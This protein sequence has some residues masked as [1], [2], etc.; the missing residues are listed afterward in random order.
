VRRRPGETLSPVRVELTR[1]AAVSGEIVDLSGAPVAGTE[2]TVG[3]E[4]PASEPLGTLVADRNGR[5]R[6]SSLAAGMRYYLYTRA[7]GFA[8]ALTIVHAP[9][10][11]PPPPDEFP[12]PSAVAK[13]LRI[14]L[15]TGGSIIGKV[16]D[17]TG[18]PLDD[19]H[20]HLTPTEGT[21][22]WISSWCG[23]DAFR[24]VRSG[25]AGAFEFVHLAANRYRLRATGRGLAPWSREAIVVSGRTARIDLGT[26]TLQ[27][28]GILD[29]QVVDSRGAPVPAASA[30]LSASDG[31]PSF[32]LEDS[33]PSQAVTGP[34][35]KV[36]FADL[37]PGARYDLE[38]HHSEHPETTVKGISIPTA[39][40]LRIE[41]QEGRRL[42]GHV[43]GADGQPIAGASL[44]VVGT[45]HQSFLALL[46]SP[47]SVT[48]AKGEFSLSG[49]APGT[50]QLEAT[51]DGFR[52]S[53]AAALIPDVESAR[54]VEIVL[55][56]AGWLVGS[57]RDT[58]GNPVD[59][60]VAVTPR[61]VPSSP[62][63]GLERSRMG[64]TD[65]S[66]EYRVE[67]LD[68]GTYTVTARPMRRMGSGKPG[69]PIEIRLG[70]NTLDIVVE[71]E[72]GWEVSG[73]VVDS[74]G[75]PVDDVTLQLT[76]A[77]AGTSPVTTSFADGSFV[78]TDVA[79]GIYTPSA[80]RHGYLM[81]A[82]AA[83]VTVAG[84]PVSG[85]RLSLSRTEALIS[86]RLLHLAAAEMAGVRIE[87]KR[88][89]PDNFELTQRNGW[90]F[91]PG[92]IAV[93]P[94]PGTYQITDLTAGLWSV[95]ATAAAGRHAGGRVD[96]DSDRAM[97]VLDLE[98]AAGAILSGRVTMAERPVAGVL[99]VLGSSSGQAGTPVAMA[100][101]AADGTFTLPSSPLGTFE[102]GIVDFRVG[103]LDHRTVELTADQALTISLPS[104]A[105]HGTVS[106]RTT[107]LPISGAYVVLTRS[108][109]PLGALVGSPAAAQT[110]DSGAFD[111]ASVAPGHYQ[112]TVTRP[113]FAPGQ[114]TLHVA[115]DGTAAIAMQLVPSSTA[116]ATPTAPPESAEPTGPPAEPNPLGP[117]S[118]R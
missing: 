12:P 75:N 42:T 10:A 49:L 56:P 85:L 37:V 14:V 79:D 105:V 57:V 41:L 50:L 33:L 117:G 110:D 44:G 71:P 59:A 69:P 47:D 118:A 54:P 97:A 86:G 3:K 78:F 52:R 80:R 48:N 5:F 92:G 115:A 16:V 108:D 112:V 94:S 65:A 81:T 23:E 113:G 4:T 60:L 63:D 26:L 84:G 114:D 83:P 88:I 32:A 28:G 89:G 9:A 95:T 68:P 107:G 18:R 109:A 45:M 100:E 51:A 53:R 25:R 34:D 20:L 82:D 99:V 73:Q 98:F 87:A 6:L 64:T 74:A 17:G 76:P 104:G 90:P 55:E 8:S 116:P 38:I 39:G 11:A 103:L 101:T 31:Q 72:K 93:D 22:S 61:G 91:E 24:T 13:P 66:G 46:R 62:L 2:I 7:P 106:A 36:H 96:L 111:I 30:M 15:E 43:V 1:A 58:A 67:A 35:G 70:P 27:P 29:A 19:I 102:L 77:A 21:F 40:L